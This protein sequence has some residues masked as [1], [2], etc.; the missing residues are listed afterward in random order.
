MATIPSIID[1]FPANGAQGIVL[2]DRVTVTFDQEMDETTINDGTFVLLGPDKSTLFSPMNITPF[3]IPGTDEEDI[4]SSPYVQGYIKGTIS[5]QKVDQYGSLIDQD[6]K[7]Y[8]GDG[9][10]WY[11]KAIFTPDAPLESNKQY[12]VI[13]AGDETP[14]DDFESGIKT[15]T[16]FDTQKTAGTG[17]AILYYYGGYTG[18]NNRSYTLRFTSAGSV[19]QAEYEWWDDTDPLTVYSGVSSTGERELE[20]GICVTCDPD[21]SFQI[22][23]T[24]T[25]VVVPAL[26]LEGNYRWSFSTGSGSIQV[27]PSS[28]SASGID[29]ITGVSELEIVSITPKHQATNL[30]PLSVSEIIIE[31]NKDLD[32]DTITNDTVRIFSEPVNGLLDTNIQYAGEIVKILSVDANIL[33]I[34]IS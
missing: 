18:E 7:D 34:Q 10:L 31:F 2:S 21:G 30:D 3:D 33:T 32:P 12:Q 8:T 22:G 20:D 6:T 24:F 19:G 28:T 23:D 29:S 11:T 15:R 14:D 27:P 1:S 5:F 26:A 9:T 17:T 4:N 16:V 25:V 13:L